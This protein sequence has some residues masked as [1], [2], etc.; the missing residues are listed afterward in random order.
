MCLAQFI[1]FQ[2]CCSLISD[3][4]ASRML[5]LSFAVR[6]L[7]S[8]ME[9]AEVHGEGLRVYL[10]NVTPGTSFLVSDSLGKQ[11]CSIPP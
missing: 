8:L 1:T 3:R 5:V 6:G 11:F 2:I 4:L 9:K 10:L 7:F